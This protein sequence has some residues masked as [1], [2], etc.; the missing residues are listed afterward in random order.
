MS[1]RSS[2]PENRDSREFPD[3][4]GGASRARL[5]WGVGL[6]LVVG[7]VTALLRVHAR[8]WREIVLR[9]GATALVFGLLAWFEGDTFW[10]NPGF[11]ICAAGAV[12]AL[13]VFI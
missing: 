13:L 12:G 6:G 10:R 2:D 8:T 3:L 4:P 5:L 1:K 11:W 9:M 7:F